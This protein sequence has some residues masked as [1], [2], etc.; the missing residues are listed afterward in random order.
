MSYPIKVMSVIELLK[1]EIQTII[2]KL[3]FHTWLNIL[4]KIVISKQSKLPC[5]NLNFYNF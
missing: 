2:L 1:C 3:Q 4:L 5:E